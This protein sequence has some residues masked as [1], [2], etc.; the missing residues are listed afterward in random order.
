MSDTYNVKQGGH[1]LWIQI[2]G[3][4]STRFELQFWLYLTFTNKYVYEQL[5]PGVLEEL[6]KKNPTTEKGFRKRRHHQYLTENVGIPHLDKHLI[7]LI[8]VMELSNNMTEFK[9]NFDRVFRSIQ[10]LKLPLE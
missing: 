5:P 2:G 10:Q 9:E 7:K 6:K 4:P 3:Y 1:P 8:T